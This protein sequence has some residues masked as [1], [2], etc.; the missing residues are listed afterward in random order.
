MPLAHR[1]QN[2]QQCLQNFHCDLLQYFLQWNQ[3]TFQLENHHCIHHR[4]HQLFQQQI[5]QVSL[6]FIV[7][8]TFHS[9][10][11][12]S[13]ILWFFVIEINCLKRKLELVLDSLRSKP[14]S[15]KGTFILFLV[16]YL[17]IISIITT[18]CLSCSNAYKISIAISFNETK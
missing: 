13:V 15:S 18:H 1:H 4:S 6:R 7:L 14:D 11:C 10:L 12:L 3:V 2:L 9:N 16:N 8:V 17:Q 5:Q